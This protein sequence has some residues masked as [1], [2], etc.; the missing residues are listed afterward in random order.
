MSTVI[1]TPPAPPAGV[2]VVETS[3]HDTTPPPPGVRRIPGRLTE[4]ESPALF[5]W[6]YG[7]KV[8][9]V[10]GYCGKGLAVVATAAEHVWLLDNF[11]RYPGGWSAV[12]GE[13]KATVEGAG[14]NEKVDLLFYGGPDC[15]GADPLP[16]F[17]TVYVDADWPDQEEAQDWALKALPKGGRLIFHAGGDV[18]QMTV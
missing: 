7:R 12:A 18:R 17:D 9:Q 1:T 5:T 3:F 15:M 6:C 4:A 13:C 2:S 14:V 11:A 10:G 8:L 16:E